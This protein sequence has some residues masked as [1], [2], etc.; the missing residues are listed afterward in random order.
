MSTKSWSPRSLTA[1]AMGKIDPV[2]KAV[3]PPIHVATTYIRDE[4]NGYSTGF[5]YGRP[6]NETT[7]EAES[8]LAMLE[9]A[10]GGALLFGSGSA[11]ATAVF[12][13]LSPGDHVVASKVMYWALRN[14][15]MTEAKRWGLNVEFVETDDLA[16]LKAAVKPGVT[17]L[18]W[19]ET[20]S[21]PLWT[22]TDIAAVAEIAHKAG[23]KLAVDSTCASPVH[24]RPLT[25]GADIVMHSATKVL[26]GHSD[27]IAG[28][29]CARED[30]EFWSRIKTVRRGQGGIL[31]PFE[32]YLLMRGMRTLHVRQER[33]SASAMALAQRLSAH[34][35][36]A[37]V[38]YPGLP[39]HPGH[40][41]AARQMENGFGFMLS[42]QVTGGE[43]AAI[44]TAAHVELYKRAT[45]LGGVE[46]LIEHR[47]SI[48]GAG[49]PCPT[50]LLR[51]STGIEDVE[52]LYADFD[53]AL[54]A[55]HG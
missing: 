40:D 55:G 19:A 4:D 34:P 8:L 23:A 48:E 17:K 28:A 15:L 45:S 54:K 6:D 31:G 32:A 27:V 35:L 47:A 30:D 29:L 12:L 25:L 52:D 13:A 21:N 1:Q 24:T 7:R 10:K 9:E 41:I 33:Q 42:V 14:W 20:P 38:L 16:A 36:V 5:I 11:A 37:R 18:I 53:Q 2:T 3:V 50:D 46:S 39:Q 22:I 26:N 44:R 49:S 51:L 43:Q